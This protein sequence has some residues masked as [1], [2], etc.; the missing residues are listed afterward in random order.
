MVPG[1][2]SDIIIYGCSRPEEETYVTTT[3][4]DG[5]CSECQYRYVKEIRKV[6]K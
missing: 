4:C 1:W 6:F 5:Q 2:K 3:S